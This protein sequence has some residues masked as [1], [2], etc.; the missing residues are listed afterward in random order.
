M[1]TNAPAPKAKKQTAATNS[2]TSSASTGMFA[3]GT[4]LAAILSFLFAFGAGKLAYQ[5]Y[6]SGLLALA[7]FFFSP[8]FYTYYALAVGGTPCVAPLI[9]GGR[10]RR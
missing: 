1:Q 7:A 2:A 8:L 4:V 3:F 9:M 6:N 5:H 10:R